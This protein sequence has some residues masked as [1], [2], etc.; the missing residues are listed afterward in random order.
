[1]PAPPFVRFAFA[2]SLVLCGLGTVAHADCGDE[3][4]ELLQL[5]L[6]EKGIAAVLNAST[7]MCMPCGGFGQIACGDDGNRSCDA[8]LDVFPRIKGLTDKIVAAVGT[9]EYEVEGTGITV[10]PGEF[11][12]DIARRVAN[13]LQFCLRPVRFARRAPPPESAAPETDRRT[14]VLIPGMGYTLPL[15]AFHASDNP[16]PRLVRENHQ[17]VYAVD[18][19]AGGQV[20]DAGR[21]HPLRMFELGPGGDL[22]PAAQGKRRYT[23]R[24]ITFQEV[25]TDIAT[26]L[27]TVPIEG[28][29]HLLAF[30][31]GGFIAKDL[32]YNHAHNLEKA[33][34]QISGVTFLAHPHFGERGVSG[35]DMATLF[36]TGLADGTFWQGSRFPKLDFSGNPS[37]SSASSAQGSVDTSDGSAAGL[38]GSGG[39]EAILA[40]TCQVGL[41]LEGWSRLMQRPGNTGS[42]VR[43][44]DNRDFPGIHWMSLAGRKSPDLAPGPQNFYTNS[45]PGDGRTPVASAMGIDAFD[46]FPSIRRLAWDDSAEHA[47]GHDY[48]CLLRAGFDRF[49]IAPPRPGLRYVVQPAD[50]LWSL[51]GAAMDNDTALQ[52]PYW[53]LLADANGLKLTDQLSPGQLLDMPVIGHTV[54]R[55]DS[56]W[57][58]T[59]KTDAQPGG[60]P[61]LHAAHPAGLTDAPD[62]IFPGRMLA[63]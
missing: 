21:P 30:S 19:N 1:M 26:L 48:S 45:L 61:R 10:D 58:V 55:G 32:M 13:R 37:S 43:S 42:Q 49:P 50:N 60:W 15:D 23:G 9:F 41:W 59:E 47:C 27:Q 20:D 29:V 63:R 14:Y 25:A 46:R 5:S 56:L 7:E 3:E 38:Q 22:T 28:T 44:I 18:F 51:A 53:R 39:A 35:A 2:F 16:L 54:A 52:D 11:S 36:C 24:N 34:V 33:G 62:L 17:R 40:Q 4:Y 12:E 57:S 6:P 8:G 31:M